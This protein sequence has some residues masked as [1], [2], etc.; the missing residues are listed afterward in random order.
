[1][2][3]VFQLIIPIVDGRTTWDKMKGMQIICSQ[4]SVLF[5]SSRLYAIASYSRNESDDYLCIRNA[6][7]TYVEFVRI[8]YC[9]KFIDLWQY[10]PIPSNHYVQSPEN[11][12]NWRLPQSFW[13]RISF[14]GVIGHQSV[15]PIVNCRTR[16]IAST[17]YPNYSL[18]TAEENQIVMS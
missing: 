14:Y 1:M 5:A 6:R 2:V 10:Y 4:I 3:I 17:I 11:E 12:N 15:W 8:V 18:D 16:S 7:F 13:T 9:L